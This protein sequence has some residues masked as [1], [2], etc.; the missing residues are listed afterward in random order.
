MHP[1]THLFTRGEIIDMQELTTVIYFLPFLYFVFLLFSSFC[2]CLPL[3]VGGFPWLFAQ[4]SH[5]MSLLWIFVLRLPRG[6]HK[7]SHR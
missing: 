1:V 3:E 4:S 6:L 7:T 2:F 5:F